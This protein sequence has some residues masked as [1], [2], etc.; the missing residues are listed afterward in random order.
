MKISHVLSIRTSLPVLFALFLLCP[1]LAN[2]VQTT[3]PALKPGY[4]PP[5]DTVLAQ[6]SRGTVT[7]TG[8][9]LF[10]DLSGGQNP[11]VFSRYKESEN[12]LEREVLRESI[13]KAV[14]NYVVTR[15]LFRK[16]PAPMGSEKLESLRLRLKSYPVFELV[17]VEE[18]LRPNLVISD[19]DVMAYYRKHQED[20]QHPPSVKIRLMYLSAPRTNMEL[21]RLKASDTM[22]GLRER[23]ME[24]EDFEELVGEHSA[25]FPGAAEGGLMEVTASEEYNRFYEEAAALEPGEFSPVF[26]REDGF[27]FLQCLEKTGALPIPVEEV[28]DQIIPILA[29]NALQYLYEL[30]LENL[31]KKYHPSVGFGAWD[32]L[33][34]DHVLLQVGKLKITKGAFWRLYPEIISEDFTLNEDMIHRQIHKIKHLECIRME[35]EKKRLAGHPFIKLGMVIAREQLAAQRFLETKWKTMKSV[36]E[37]ELK[38]YYDTHPDLARE[39]YW[40]Q[41]RDVRGEVISP[42]QYEAREL[43]DVITKMERDFRSLISDA[44]DVIQEAKA[45]GLDVETVFDQAKGE[46]PGDGLTNIARR[47]STDLYRFI[48]RDRGRVGSGSPDEVWKFVRKLEGGEFTPVLK[49]PTAIYCY[50]V[51]GSHEGEIREFKEVRGEVRNQLVRERKERVIGELLEKVAG[52]TSLKFKPVLQP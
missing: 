29:T 41:V 2:G 1:T 38:S 34:N 51:K 15:E 16:A 46:V 7:E 52:E 37:D 49:S 39:E 19:Q 47:Y 20:Y 28:K 44:E 14:K 48:V 32:K 33:G 36:T 43:G 18:V 31:L 4:S 24:G 30:E 40:K 42:A 17:W 26:Q 6:F 3:C 27:F 35:V 45:E 10:L 22:E 8:L 5:G 12:P 23:A 21:D 50:Y 9:L 11:N 25:S 13:K